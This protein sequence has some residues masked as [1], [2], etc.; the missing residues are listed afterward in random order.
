MTEPKKRKSGL[1][2]LDLWR[3]EHACQPV[4]TG[5]GTGTAGCTYLVGTAQTGGEYRDV[6]VRTILPDDEFDRLFGGEN[7]RDLWALICISIGRMVAADT[8]LPIDFQVQRMTEANEKYQ[9]QRNPVGHGHR[10]YAGGGDATA[11]KPTPTDE[12]EVA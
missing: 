12:G 3:L 7:G 1:S 5:F 8:G 10:H 11:F 9:G 6:D 2:T 4:W